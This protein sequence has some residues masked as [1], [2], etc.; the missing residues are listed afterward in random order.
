[1]S[2]Q[3]AVDKY[4]CRGFGNLKNDS[5][6][7]DCSEKAISFEEYDLYYGYGENESLSLLDRTKAYQLNNSYPEKIVIL[8]ECKHGGKKERHHPDY[9]KPFEVELLCKSCHFSRHRDLLD[10]TFNIPFSENGAYYRKIFKN[11][12]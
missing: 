9:D 1:M 8:T 5:G 3:I 10:D 12:T 11:K 4:I 6:H 2:R 7:F